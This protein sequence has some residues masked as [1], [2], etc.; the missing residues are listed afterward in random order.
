M[1]RR[2]LGR[3]FGQSLKSVMLGGFGLA[4][5]AVAALEPMPAAARVPF[6]AGGLSVL[7]GACWQWGPRR[8]VRGLAAEEASWAL[9]LSGFPFLLVSVCLGAFGHSPREAIPPLVPF[10]AITGA[11][12]AGLFRQ[13]IRSVRGIGTAEHFG[14][15]PRYDL[16]R[17]LVARG[18][19][20]GFRAEV[21]TTE[22]ACEIVLAGIPA[23]IVLEP[24]RLVD[25]RQR[26][27]AE[28]VTTGHPELDTEVHMRAD[29]PADLLARLDHE[30]R[31]LLRT[32]L[33][34]GARV[35]GGLVASR[36]ERGQSGDAGRALLALAKRLSRPL[37]REETFGLLARQAREESIPA[38]RI[39]RLQAL[40][41][42]APDIA[43][44]ALS[45][46]LADDDANVRAAAVELIF[47]DPSAPPSL[48]DAAAH[49]RLR[50]SAADGRLALA[51][52][53]AS[54]GALSEPGKAGAVSLPP[55][56]P[57]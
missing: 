34:R 52:S 45:A 19:V 50:L 30:G 48:R 40:A 35:R 4:L 7:L 33:S 41:R 24:A 54:A 5:V 28:N 17:G 26:V 14:L 13:A 6:F 25:L 8:V 37:S 47:A 16:F 32:A 57:Q 39:V 1:A 20:D 55:K 51:E 27:V 43:R 56:K 29:D 23:D 11:A 31:D 12:S 21:V 9:V 15:K 53:P 2:R 3:I 42:H 49:E 36:L 22:A 10:F 46:A 38:S 18:E 44:D